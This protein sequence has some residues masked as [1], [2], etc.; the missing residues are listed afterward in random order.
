MDYTTF[1]IINDIIKLDNDLLLPPSA[2]SN[3]ALVEACPREEARHTENGSVDSER[4]WNELCSDGRTGTRR[5]YLNVSLRT[6]PVPI[7]TDYDVSMLTPR[8]VNA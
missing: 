2:A 3:N 4:E 7:R 8:I 5:E 1:D 6:S